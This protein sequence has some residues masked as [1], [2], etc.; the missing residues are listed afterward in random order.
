MIDK[1]YGGDMVLV[2]DCIWFVPINISYLCCYDRIKNKIT[3]KI[4][5]PKCYERNF[6]YFERIVLVDNYLIGIPYSASYYFRYD[7]MADELITINLLKN[8]KEIPLPYLSLTIPKEKKLYSF[9]RFMDYGLKET[10]KAFVFDP[11]NLEISYMEL[12]DSID[13]IFTGTRSE[14]FRR[15]AL[16][17]GQDLIVL[18]GDKKEMN[19]IGFCADDVSTNDI[20]CTDCYIQTIT[21]IGDDRNLLLDKN[22]KAWI[23]N[24]YNNTISVIN[25]NIKVKTEFYDN[26]IFSF[27]IRHNDSVY[28]FPSYGD[29]ILEYDINANKFDEAFFSQD[30]TNNE[31]A[32]KMGMIGREYEQF[33]KPHIIGNRLVF[34]NLWNKKLYDV[35]LDNKKISYKDVYI[36]LDNDDVFEEMKYI[37]KMEKIITEYGMNAFSNLKSFVCYL[38]K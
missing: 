9:R 23:W 35:D 22:G 5:L 36:E 14:A 16:L 30:V 21:N 17:L 15:E 1:V 25:N 6:R 8:H 24:A 26:D 32:S 20:I 19:R 11:H 28:I 10:H 34:W 31:I 13:F 7:I 27:S 29:K 33:S 12:D 37:S 18:R 4:P 3:K 38:T 2:G